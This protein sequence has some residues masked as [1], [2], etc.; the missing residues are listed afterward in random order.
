MCLKLANLLELTE[1]SLHPADE[2]VHLFQGRAVGHGG[3]DLQNGLLVAGEIA[4]L[5]DLLHEQAQ[6][7]T[8]ALVQDRLYRLFP[9]IGRYPFIIGMDPER[10]PC[11]QRFLW[12]FRGQLDLFR[13]QEHRQTENQKQQQAS[14]LLPTP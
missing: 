8:Q 14:R 4:A 11:R 2:V 5:I 9:G 12:V 3:S 6:C 13:Q 7:A 1:E 10:I